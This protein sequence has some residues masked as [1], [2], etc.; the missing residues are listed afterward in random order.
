MDHAQSIPAGVRRSSER[1]LLEEMFTAL[2]AASSFVRMGTV[3]SAAPA[4][5]PAVGP[6]VGPAP[7][8]RRESRR[9]REQA[10]FDPELHLVPPFRGW[11]RY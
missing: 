5:A 4:L 1:H 6:V 7:R 9:W 11:V 2:A 8:R 3:A 10:P